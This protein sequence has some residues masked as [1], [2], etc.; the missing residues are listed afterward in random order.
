MY[1]LQE[2]WYLSKIRHDAPDKYKLWFA[3]LFLKIETVLPVLTKN[4]CVICKLFLKIE[5]DLG[6][7]GV[8]LRYI[9]SF[10]FST[11]QDFG[12]ESSNFSK[13]CFNV[14]EFGRSNKCHLHLSGYILNLRPSTFCISVTILSLIDCR[15]FLRR[16]L[17][18]RELRRPSEWIYFF[19]SSLERSDSTYRPFAFLG[20][21]PFPQIDLLSQDFNGQLPLVVVIIFLHFF[22]TQCFWLIISQLKILIIITT[23]I[24]IVGLCVRGSSVIQYLSCRSSCFSCSSSLMLP[25]AFHQLTY[26]HFKQ[27]TSSTV[28]MSS[29]NS[30]TARSMQ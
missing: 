12:C 8:P 17:F 6:Q 25:T 24:I 7:V 19:W 11:T 4:T 23:G 5:T 30:N 15:I 3:I 16:A 14:S 18:S 28:A 26:A 13:K 20:Y 10:L 9:F 22:P 21:F 2:T 1:N 27:G 29:A